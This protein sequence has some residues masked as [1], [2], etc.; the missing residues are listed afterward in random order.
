MP[1]LDNVFG[2]GNAGFSSGPK[3]PRAYTSQEVAE[4]VKSVFVSGGERDIMLGDAV[5]IYT[6]ERNGTLRHEVFLLKRD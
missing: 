3:P 2:S 6:L 4:I 1:I 5:D